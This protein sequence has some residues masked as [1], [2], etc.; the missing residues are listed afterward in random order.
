M[1]DEYVRCYTR[2]GATAD[3]VT[4]VQQHMREAAQRRAQ[5]S[6]PRSGAGGPQDTD[7]GRPP[8]S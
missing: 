6:G 7:P 5:R 4:E 2:P 8:A 3:I 1:L